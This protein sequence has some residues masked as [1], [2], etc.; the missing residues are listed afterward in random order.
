MSRDC[1]AGRAG[2]REAAGSVDY[3]EGVRGHAPSISDVVD[4]VLSRPDDALCPSATAPATPTRSPTVHPR[5]TPI[6]HRMARP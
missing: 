6:R 1:H 2:L 5:G 3:R 4:L